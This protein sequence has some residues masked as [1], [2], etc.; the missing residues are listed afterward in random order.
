MFYWENW[1]LQSLDFVDSS[2][3]ALSKL[4]IFFKHGPVQINKSD[5]WLTKV[6]GL[7][8]LRCRWNHKTFT[9]HRP[10]EASWAVVFC[11]VRG[12]LGCVSI[13]TGK[14]DHFAVLFLND[15]LDLILV[16]AIFTLVNPDLLLSFFVS[17]TWLLNVYQVQ[18][19][20]C[21]LQQWRC[22]IG[23]WSL[24]PVRF[25]HGRV[26][27]NFDRVHALSVIHRRQSAILADQVIQQ[28]II[29]L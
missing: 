29:V 23:G 11:I 27:E 18:F 10:D 1:I 14:L 5:R 20:L 22:L 16:V 6:I 13:I 24:G 9:F 26:G 17:D 21:C 12:V 19:W 15:E 28:V 25:L 4:A 3:G 8:D 2:I 7:I